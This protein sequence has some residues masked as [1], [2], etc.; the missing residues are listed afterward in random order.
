MNVETSKN[1][2]GIGAILIVIA[3][4]GAFG[5]GFAGLLGLIGLILLLIGTKGLADHYSD[6]GIFNNALYAIILIIVGIVVAVGV[7]VAVAFAAFSDLGID[8]NDWAAFDQNWAKLIQSFTDFSDFNAIFTLIGGIIMGLV[9]LFV[10][11]IVAA[12]LYRRS[13]NTLAAKTG[14]G[15]FNTAGLILLIGAV[16]TI[17]VIGFIL[18]W[19][20]F[21]LV[22]VAFFSIKTTAAAQ[23][24]TP[25][26]P[27]S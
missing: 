21:I 4:L 11:L 3:F 26:P 22:A 25:P 2:G 24:A 8:M 1:M 14:V 23:P 15:M 9:I 6:Q 19:V 27:P 16:L 7:V 17:I 12:F 13:L 18:I 10:F 5:S 20:A